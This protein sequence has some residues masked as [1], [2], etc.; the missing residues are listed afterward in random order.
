[1]RCLRCAGEVRVIDHAAI[2]VGDARLRLART[3]CKAC[4]AER[5]IYFRLGTTLAS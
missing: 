4:G 2:V 5:A 3:T 1:M